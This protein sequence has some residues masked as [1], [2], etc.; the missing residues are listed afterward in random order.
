MKKIHILFLAV[1]SLIISTAKGQTADDIINKVIQATGGKEKIAQVKT[2]YTE[3]SVD[4]MGTSSPS[5]EYLVNGKGF[6]SEAEFNGTKIVNCYT[7]KGGWSINPFFGNPDPQAMPDEAYKAGKDLIYF[8]ASLF[9]YS[10]KGN[11][12]ELIGKEGNNY[13]LKVISGGIETNVY[14][15]TATYYI[16]KTV[17][18]GD[19]GGNPIEITINLSD[20]KKTDFGV[21]L[22]YTRVTDL[23]GFS[24]SA[25]ITKVEVN[26]DIDLKIFDMPK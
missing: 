26:K 10:A 21:T 1:T 24:L 2:V 20:Y 22:P 13:K 4:A 5:V 14:V 8:G 12:V 7:D 6:K 18:K 15:D 3:Y 9:D 19:F 25:K 23:G 11:N 17:A 16:N